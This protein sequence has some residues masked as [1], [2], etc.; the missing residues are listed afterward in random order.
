MLNILTTEEKKKILVE[1]RLRLTV[2]SVFAVSSIAIASAVLLAP[3]YVLSISKYNAAE[4]QHAVLEGKYGGTGQ[5]KDIGAQIRDINT[6]V[7]LLLSGDTTARLF[8]SQA[9]SKI[10]SLKGNKIKIFSFSYET[11]ENQERIVLTGTATNR[12]SLANFIETLKKDPTFTSVT[13]PISS[14][15]KSENIDFS[16]VAERK[17]KSSAKK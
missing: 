15:V 5:E 8:P 16:I 2:V 14:Y 10:L 13:L 9:V 1:Y 4:K 17:A 7:L 3:A 11:T 6:R 12:D